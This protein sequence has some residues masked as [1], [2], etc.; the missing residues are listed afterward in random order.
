MV[1]VCQVGL[2]G[3]VVLFYRNKRRWGW[4]SFFSAHLPWRWKKVTLYHE[5]D[6]QRLKKGVWI[7]KFISE[8]IYLNFDVFVIRFVMNCNFHVESPQY[9]TSW[10]II[11][12]SKAIVTCNYKCISLMPTG[13]VI[14]THSERSASTSKI[15][16]K[17]RGGADA[18]N[19]IPPNVLAHG[20][21][22]IFY[23]KNIWMSALWSA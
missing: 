5:G 12:A 21:L 13:D 11:W 2:K 23:A 19:P 17:S 4:C 15:N 14:S 8:K 10:L 3:M 6:L 1:R 16:V 9:A 18:G 7:K 20:T 22:D